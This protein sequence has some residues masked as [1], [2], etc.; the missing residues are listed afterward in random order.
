MNASS[1]AKLSQVN[2]A[3]A[4]IVRQLAAAVSSKYGGTIQVISGYRSYASQAALYANRANNPN[5]VA[6]PGTSKHEKG[7]AVDLRFSGVSANT[8]GVLGES[9]GLRWGGRFSKRDPG[10]FELMDLTSYVPTRGNSSMPRVL[11]PSASP[12]PFNQSKPGVDVEHP[13]VQATDLYFVGALF[14]LA[15]LTKW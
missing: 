11:T 14:L 1:Q 7:L 5:P 15:L 2:P 6:V 4:N 8:V 9:M 13:Q 12:A 3:L 10:H